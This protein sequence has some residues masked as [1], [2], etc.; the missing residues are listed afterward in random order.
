MRLLVQE[1]A[2]CLDCARELR[3]QYK[4]MCLRGDATRKSIDQLKNLI[5]NYLGKAVSVHTLARQRSSIKAFYFAMKDGTYEIYLLAGM[6]DE[7]KRFAYCKELFHVVIDVE[8]YH[9]TNLHDHVYEVVATF[10]VTD[11]TP[12]PSVQSEKLAE[13]AAMEFMFPYEDRQHILEGTKN[14][15]AAE[16][17]SR[18]GVP[19]PYI[20]LYCSEGHMGF[21]HA[22]RADPVTDAAQ[23]S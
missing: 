4:L 14:P 11:S 20:E 9:N 6:G 7:E 1:I 2:R 12:S 23:P 16:I 17:A 3:E 10:P 18:Y 13:L 15:D 5:E 21:A 22:F 19:Q 8:A